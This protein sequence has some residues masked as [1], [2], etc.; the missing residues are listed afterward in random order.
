MKNEIRTEFLGVEL[1]SP[2][3]LPAGVLDISFSSMNQVSAVGAGLV[4]TKSLTI[5]SRKGHDGPVVAEVEGGMLNAM[6]LCNPGIDAGLEELK[7]LKTA[8]E[9]DVEG[10]GNCPVNVSIFATDVNGFSDLA[11]RV[12]NSEADFLELNLSCPNVMDEFGVPLA[13]S[14]K[15]VAEIITAVKSVCVKPVIAKLSPNVTSLTR[16]AGA[17]AEAGADAL[18]MINTLGP[19]LE[20]DIEAGRPVLSNISGG[21][22]GPCVKPVALRLV[23]ECRKSGLSLP[24]I[25]MGGI[26]T[27]ED[28]VQMLMAGADLVGVGTAVY[29]RGPG[30]FGLINEELLSFLKRKGLESI[31][32]INRII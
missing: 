25:G 22:S 10:P 1:S 12:N 15:T 26:T 16:I 32:D 17:A 18:C 29:Y 8:A 21:L 6:G 31:T 4:T 3:V 7:L 2:L 19:G 20:I 13:A 9:A 5:E 30:V 28:A 23:Y 27:G 11:E 14:E 24:I